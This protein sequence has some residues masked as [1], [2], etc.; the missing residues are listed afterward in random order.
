MRGENVY[1]KGVLEEV[2]SVEKV[3]KEMIYVL[4]TSGKLTEQDVTTIIN[5]TAKGK[6]VV[7]EKEIENIVLY[8]KKDVIKAKTGTQI[9]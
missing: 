2:E 8:T 7:A 5:L 1:I 4:N 9:E 6:E 3:F